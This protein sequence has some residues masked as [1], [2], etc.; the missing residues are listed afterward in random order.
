MPRAALPCGLP[1]CTA[2]TLP[3][4]NPNFDCAGLPWRR[5]HRGRPF[6]LLRRI[7]PPSSPSAAE[8]RDARGSLSPLP[9]VSLWEAGRH[10]WASVGLHRCHA[11]IRLSA[12][13]DAM[14]VPGRRGCIEHDPNNKRG[15]EQDFCHVRHC[16]IL[17]RCY[18]RLA[19]RRPLR[20]RSDQDHYA[21]AYEIRLGK[22]R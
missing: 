15:G 3:V 18:V 9:V 10:R 13:N 8:P 4:N 6:L 2:G 1:F 21:V 22:F 14:V 17:S 12:V 20:G 7:L 5:V 16:T 19:V 11:G